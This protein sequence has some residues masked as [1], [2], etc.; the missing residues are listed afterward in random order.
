MDERSPGLPVSLLRCARLAV[1]LAY[2]VLLAIF[3]PHLHQM[4]RRRILVSRRAGTQIFYR[5]ANPKI[6]DAFDLIQKILCERM[7][8]E[9]AL[10]R[11]GRRK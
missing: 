3:Y 7:E 11:E 8:D 1:H 9:A 6:L 2:A 5:I 10:A 4:K